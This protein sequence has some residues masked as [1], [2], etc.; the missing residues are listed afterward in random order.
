[1]TFEAD[2]EL[3]IMAIIPL[4]PLQLLHKQAVIS[5]VGLFCDTVSVTLVKLSGTYD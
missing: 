1:M 2:L 5:T 3:L 4:V